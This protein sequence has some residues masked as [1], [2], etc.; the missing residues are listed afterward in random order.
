M[1]EV[2]IGGGENG[3][4]IVHDLVCLVDDV[5]RVHGA[6]GGVNGN[7]AGDIQRLAGQDGLAVGS[8]G[9]R[10]VGSVDDLLFH[11][12]KVRVFGGAF[13]WQVIGI[14]AT[15]MSAY[16]IAVIEGKSRVKEWLAGRLP[17]GWEYVAVEEVSELELHRDAVLFMDLS[18]SN[19]KERVRQLSRLLPVPVMIHSMTDTLKDIGQPFIR[20]NAWPGML[21]REIHELAIPEQGMEQTLSFLD[22]LYKQLGGRYRIV[23]DLPGMISG[24]ILATII[25]EAYYTLQEEV[26]T[27]E[28]IDTAMKLGTNYPFGPFEWSEKIGLENIYDLLNKL[29]RADD[30]YR[31][32]PAMKEALAILKCD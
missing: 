9:S 18:F 1:A 17:S 27:K 16:K 21:E 12:C 26:S 22:E 32:A 28:E 4:Q 7:L 3:F 11:A 20:I 13:G 24:R 31:P 6:C 5:S 30:R 14:F 15:I 29:S 19:D 10:G 8:Y 23:P 2:H 25:S